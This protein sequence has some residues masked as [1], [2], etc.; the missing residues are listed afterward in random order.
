MNTA[1]AKRYAHKLA[2]DAL[3]V[4]HDAVPNGPD[5]AAIKRALILMAETHSRF[6]P[7]TTDREPRKPEYKGEPLQ[8]DPP[9]AH[10]H[11][12]RYEHGSAAIGQCQCGAWQ[13]N[14]NI[15]VAE[16]NTDSTPA[17][18]DAEV[19]EGSDCDRP[20]GCDEKCPPCVD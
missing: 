2:S 16:A 18:S 1:E 3:I 17:I 13:V 9:D 5:A 10:E 8:F 14:G 19:G 12:Y 11:D 4:A 7:R 20:G 15:S 6:G